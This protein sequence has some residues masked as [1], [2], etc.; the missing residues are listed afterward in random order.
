MSPTGQKLEALPASAVT[1]PPDM[2]EAI[3]HGHGRAGMLAMQEDFVASAMADAPGSF[4]SGRNGAPVMPMLSN[5]FEAPPH[6]GPVADAKV[7]FEPVKVFV[8]AAP[9]WTGPV[10]AAR[11]GSDEDAASPVTAY[12]G[13]KSAKPDEGA[14]APMALKS[15]VRPPARLRRLHV[16]PQARAR[17]AAAARRVARKPHP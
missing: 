11:G 13:D 7:T 5:V 9:G 15:A 6:S 14:G 3:C 10:L 16:T 2:R 4:V 8:G 1:S 12:T 17:M